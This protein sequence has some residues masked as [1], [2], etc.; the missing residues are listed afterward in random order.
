MGF[1]YIKIYNARPQ[2]SG[3]AVGVKGNERTGTAQFEF[4]TSDET[5]TNAAL[6]IIA[7]FAE[8]PLFSEASPDSTT[9]LLGMN[10]PEDAT[11]GAWSKRVGKGVYAYSIGYDELDADD[12]KA[13]A[14]DKN[15][16]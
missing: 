1:Y 12:A 11:A 10:S 2:T 3:D 15:L 6:E 14:V 9:L 7:A 5:V 16:A 8:S 13:A 4:T